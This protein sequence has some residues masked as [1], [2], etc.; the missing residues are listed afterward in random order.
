M[1]REIGTTEFTAEDRTRYRD[2]VKADLEALRSL[3]A[4]RRFAVVEPTLG[5][6]LELYLID[7]D[8][9]PAPLNQQLIDLMPGERFQPELALFNGELDLPPRPLAGRAFHEAEVGL[10]GKMERLEAHARELDGHVLAVG[11]LPTLAAGDISER[12]L[13]SNPRFRALNDAILSARGEPVRL[14]IE[15]D[16][17]LIASTPSILFEAACTSL[18]CHLDAAPEDFARYWNAAQAAAG[19]LVA[20]A[21]NSP[22]FLGRALHHET[23][24]AVFEQTIDTRTEELVAQGVRP[25]VWFGERWLT[26]GA[27][28]LFEENVRYFPALLPICG[29]E[30]PFA[31]LA[32]GGVPELPELTLHNGTVYRWNRPV[33]SA[34]DGQA[35]LRIEHRALP[36]GPT[37]VDGIANAALFYGL[38]RAL[39][40]GQPPVW[41]RMSFEAARDNFYA[42]ARAGLDAP[43]SWPGAGERVPAAELLVRHLLP[44]AHDGLRAWGIDD[45]DRERLLRVIEE[46]ALSGQNGAAWQ[47]ET[48]RSLTEGQGLGSW[49]AT[50]ELVRRYSKEAATGEPVHTWPR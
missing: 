50:Q 14:R 15:G 10:R 4:D 3:L 33:Y 47:R 7:G 39:A 48:Y 1:G 23:R 13:S 42:G 20:V 49:Q 21:A 36:A 27:L 24:I 8:G 9:R 11:I 19:P 18:Q 32:T 38:V 2:K 28:E 40:D 22:F 29:D 6:E 41:E 26:E 5:I 17:E 43:M 16:E 30:D 25:R 46:R 34:A 44:L 37:V 35:R 12:N 45:G 31:V